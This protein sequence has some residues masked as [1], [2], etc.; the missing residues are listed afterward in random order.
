MEQKANLGDIFDLTFTKFVT[1]I[2]VKIAFIVVMVMAGLAWLLFIIGG[3]SSSFGAGL[4]GI[5]FGGLAFLMAV[6]LYRIM[7]ELVMVIFAIKQ[8]TDRLP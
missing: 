5:V 2:V 7:F 6:L 1:P 8:N 3:F 4:A